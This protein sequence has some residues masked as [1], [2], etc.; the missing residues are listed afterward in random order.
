MGGDKG[1]YNRRVLA[2]DPMF[3]EVGKNSA[4]K[5]KKSP[6]FNI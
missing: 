2:I 6:L 5:S 4:E 3:Y 1:Q